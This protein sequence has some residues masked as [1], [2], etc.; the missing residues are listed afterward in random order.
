MLKQL[1]KV[2]QEVKSSTYLS[3]IKRGEDNEMVILFKKCFIENKLYE[4]K[5]EKLVKIL[6]IALDNRKEKKIK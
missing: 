6:N 5:D 2:N 4:I 1:K 3:S